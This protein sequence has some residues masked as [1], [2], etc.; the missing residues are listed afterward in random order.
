MAAKI[1]YC[2]EKWVNPF[3]KSNNK[4]SPRCK[5]WAMEVG[6]SVPSIF[7]AHLDITNKNNVLFAHLM[8]ARI[9]IIYSVSQ[10]RQRWAIRVVPLDFCFCQKR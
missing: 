3:V 4:H 8:A 5:S 9:P 1:S 7:T 2:R 6:Y 10:Y